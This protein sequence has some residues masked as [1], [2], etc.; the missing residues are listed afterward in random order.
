MKRIHLLTL[1]MILFFNSISAQFLSIQGVLRNENGSTVED[2]IMS[3]H[4]TIYDAVEDGNEIWTETKDD[5]QITNGVYSHTLG[6]VE[7]FADA[8]TAFDYTQEY[9]L[10][11]KISSEPELTP[12]T[13]LTMTP[14]S[15]SF[16]AGTLNVFPSSGNVGV[17]TTNPGKE[18]DVRGNAA[19]RKLYSSNTNNSGD[20]ILQFR[21]RPIGG[22]YQDAT[23]FG[24]GAHTVIGSGG[25]ADTW[26]SNDSDPNHTGSLGNK[27]LI[28][29]S[30]Y[31]IDFWVSD[32]DW[33][34]KL[35][36]LKIDY[37]GTANFYGDIKTPHGGSLKTANS[38]GGYSEW[39]VPNDNDWMYT[40]TALNGWM[41]KTSDDES[42]IMISSNGN[43]GI[44]DDTS[45]DAKLD[46]QG[47]LMV[48]GSIM[49]GQ[50]EKQWRLVEIH[51][52][53]NSNIHGWTHN[54]TDANS[55]TDCNGNVIFG[56]YNQVAGNTE[57]IQKTWTPPAGA[58]YVK[59]VMEVYAIDSW[60]AGEWM[61][62]SLYDNT[63]GA[64]G[65]FSQQHSYDWDGGYS[66]VD[67]N[68]CGASSDD[69][70][71]R[72][73]VSARYDGSGAMKIIVANNL[74]EAPNNESIGIDNVEFWV[75]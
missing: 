72:A 21:S 42:A 3:F 31:A 74:N 67:H 26:N 29:G 65:L 16:V 61:W 48:D 51:D 58:E 63:K 27:N 32:H 68:V 66:G 33:D 35:L 69:H 2:G 5:M 36:A 71:Y 57:R 53:S 22:T 4:F 25:F 60:S 12:R 10:G 8:E 49:N 40:Y 28:L 18:L 1:T 19:V 64:A 41:I 14:T 34:D 6:S 55:T 38:S 23:Y 43:V 39:M 75:R 9:W 7:D 44:G 54:G 24:G 20:P 52:F 59:V 17:G 47:D 13:K 50:G 46:V 11:I 37:D 45:P 30:D 56:G 70:Q 62:V 15:N 73:E